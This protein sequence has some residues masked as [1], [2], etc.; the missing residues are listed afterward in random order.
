MNRKRNI[1]IFAIL[2]LVIVIGIT[3]FLTDVDFASNSFQNAVEKVKIVE[4]F[5]PPSELKPGISFTKKPSVKNTGTIPCYV[6]LFAEANDSRIGSYLNID[7]NSTD[8][9]ERQSDGYYYY[10]KVLNP[11]ET[12]TPLFTRVK[13]S[14][15]VDEKELTDFNIIVFADTVQSEGYSNM[16]DAF[17]LNRKRGS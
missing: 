6:R 1:L 12:T 14:D 8:W 5:N 4:E 11:N 10:K 3:A 2:S 9:T 7:F 16:E 17:K 15:D 13:V